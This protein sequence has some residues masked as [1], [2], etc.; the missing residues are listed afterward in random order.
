MELKQT[1]IEVIDA[2]NTEATVKVRG[3][4]DEV[5]TFVRVMLKDAGKV[6]VLEP[7]VTGSVAPAVVAS[8]TIE[9]VA[10]PP[11]QARGA[12]AKAETAPAAATEPPEKKVTKTTR[13]DVNLLLWKEG[14]THYAQVEAGQ[15]PNIAG[16]SAPGADV[17]DAIEAVLKQVRAKINPN[18]APTVTAAPVPSTP[19]PILIAV[20][21]QPATEAPA[22]LMACSNFR[23]VMDYLLANG[24]SIKD[25]NKI[26]VECLR[27]K[28]VVPA[29]ARLA[30]DMGDRVR[31]AVEVIEMEQS[32]GA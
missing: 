19:A 4:L 28:A 5:M 18:P 26:I 7:V 3:T 15:N 1:N 27:F 2:N 29:L 30:G 6:G 11:K 12:K 9:Q 20:E 25:P 17:E 24:F 23:G 32:A 16:L 21:V 13:E 14:L 22:G 10:T 31:R 8:P